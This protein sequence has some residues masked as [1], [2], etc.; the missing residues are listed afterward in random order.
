VDS[1]TIGRS[2]LIMGALIALT[3]AGVL[4][5]SRIPF[6]RRL[7]GDI[8]FETDGFSFFLP[9]VTC[10]LLSIILTVVI[11]VAIRLFR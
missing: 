10:I 11:N 6:L 4:I 9:V 2:L 1:E 7:P 3:G 8:S 5:F